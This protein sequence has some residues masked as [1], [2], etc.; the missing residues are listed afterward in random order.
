M[1]RCAQHD[2]GVDGV[3]GMTRPLHATVARIVSRNAA[4]LYGFNVPDR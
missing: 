1:F 2:T 4:E 3:P